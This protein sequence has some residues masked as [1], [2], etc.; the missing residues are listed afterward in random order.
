MKSLRALLLAV[1]LLW[2]FGVTVA[3][4]YLL[5][6]VPRAQESV[7]QG[8]SPTRDHSPQKQPEQLPESPA[9]QPPEGK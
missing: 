2:N 3:L 6:G 4:G 9:T 7:A 8:D 1:L 5:M